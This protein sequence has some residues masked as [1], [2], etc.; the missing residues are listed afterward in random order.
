MNDAPKPWSE[1]EYLT[2][3]SP[4]FHILAPKPP[5]VAAMLIIL[6]FVSVLGVSTAYLKYQEIQNIYH[7]TPQPEPLSYRNSMYGFQVA[8]PETWHGFTV[9][10]NE[11]DI[12]DVSSGESRVVG[13]FPQ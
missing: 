8:L 3:L 9:V 6:A 10:E 12:R 5:I 2:S 11:K 4:S 7:S 1:E 13:Q